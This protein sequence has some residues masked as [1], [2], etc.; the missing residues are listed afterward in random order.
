MGPQ[1]WGKMPTKF[2]WFSPPRSESARR[3]DPFMRRGFTVMIQKSKPDKVPVQTKCPNCKTDVLYYSDGT[4]R[5][6]VCMTCG[7]EVTL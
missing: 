3:K 1:N 7:K 2:V 5:D 6:H 4:K